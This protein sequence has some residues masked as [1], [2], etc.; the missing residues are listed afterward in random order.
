MYWASF[1]GPGFDRKPNY[2]VSQKKTVTFVF[3]ITLSKFY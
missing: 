3:V 1:V 2:T